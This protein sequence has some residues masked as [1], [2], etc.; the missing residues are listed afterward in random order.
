MEHGLSL[1]ET[2]I[3]V[4]D[5]KGEVV[6]EKK[7]LSE[8]EARFWNGFAARQRDRR[9]RGFRESSQGG[10]RRVLRSIVIQILALLLIAAFPA[11]ANRL[12]NFMFG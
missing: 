1:E 2:S 8:P 12:P 9:R 5:E 6:V 10:L 7:V 4:V 11:M 3:C